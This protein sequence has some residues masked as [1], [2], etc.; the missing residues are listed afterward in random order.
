MK[1]RR[2]ANILGIAALA[3]AGTALAHPGHGTPGPLHTM[4]DHSGLALLAL[5]VLAVLAGP[6]LAA[7]LRSRRSQRQEQRP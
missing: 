7:R 1:T 6:R 2:F 3:A 4:L 5:V